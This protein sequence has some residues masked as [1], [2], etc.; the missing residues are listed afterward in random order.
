MP[1]PGPD[2][3]R[4]SVMG[5]RERLLQGTSPI[6]FISKTWLRTG[7]SS[8]YARWYGPGVHRVTMR[9]AKKS[10]YQIFNSSTEELLSKS[11]TKRS[12]IPPTSAMTN[13]FI[14]RRQPFKLLCVL[15]TVVTLL[16]KLPGWAV[17]YIFRSGRQRPSWSFKRALVASISNHVVS[18]LELWVPH[19]TSNRSTEF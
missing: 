3:D 5:G 14:F 18:A 13:P 15:S 4:R 2:S 11:N 10:R 1:L 6:P 16:V 8:H 7:L 19:A 9:D 17:L 12:S